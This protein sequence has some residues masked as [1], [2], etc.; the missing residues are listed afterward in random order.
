[1]L[2]RSCHLVLGIFV[3]TLCTTPGFG[4]RDVGKIPVGATAYLVCHGHLLAH[5]DQEFIGTN[6]VPILVDGT[7][8]PAALETFNGTSD[9]PEASA[10]TQFQRF[11][12][13]SSGGTATGQC[14]VSESLS[15]AQAML[16]FWQG[17]YGP[18]ANAKPQP[19]SWP[20]PAPNLPV[21]RNAA[22]R[23]AADTKAPSKQLGA[24]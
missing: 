13:A 18:P 20:G 17:E 24:K 5:E 21:D 7:I 19:I 8:D 12:E 23:A 1:M 14:H 3:A 15:A 2:S 6:P 9:T 4:R 22:R 11:L 10:S 16:D